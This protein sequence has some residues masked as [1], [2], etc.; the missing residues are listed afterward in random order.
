MYETIT[1]FIRGETSQTHFN[2]FNH[3]L[4]RFSRK[5]NNNEE[6]SHSSNL[7]VKEKKKVCHLLSN[8]M[9]HCSIILI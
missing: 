4:P 8:S 5:N 9:S 3:W 6:F 2:H 7:T 1:D